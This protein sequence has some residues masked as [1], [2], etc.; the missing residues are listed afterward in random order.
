MFK[1]DEL[2]KLLKTSIFGQNL[3]YFNEMDSTNSYLMNLARQGAPEGTLVITDFQ[4]SGKGR[5]NR[6]WQSPPGKNLLF[7]LLLRPE[8][9]IEFVRKITLATSSVLAES[10]EQYLHK[11]HLPPVH[12]HLK[13][14]ND[15]LIDQ[16]KLA[17]IL[18]ESVLHNKDISFLVIGIGLNLNATKQDFSPDLKELATSL[19]EYT[20]HE[21]EREKLLARFLTYYEKAYVHWERTF[22]EGVV[23][24]WKKR[25]RQFHTPIRVHTVEG[26]EEATFEDIDSSGYLIYKN[27]SGRTKQLISGEVTCF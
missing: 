27:S 23:D 16:K 20:G 15:L 22:Y 5:Q 10:I 7:S 8:L 12:I 25:C 2:R 1:E 19:F 13:W 24:R 18:S 14:P 9:S 26:T 11:N 17:G 4:T 21:I 3:F 6:V